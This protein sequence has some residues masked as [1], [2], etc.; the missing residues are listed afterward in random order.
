MVTLVVLGGL[1]WL[2]IK[3]GGIG[4]FAVTRTTPARSTP[5]VS[6]DFRP[7]DQPGAG[8]VAPTL[9][10]PGPF[11]APTQA[12]G[13]HRLPTAAGSTIR[14]AS[15]NIQVFGST[16]AGKPP[17]IRT[18]AEIVRQFDVVAIQEVRSKNDY[19]IPNFVKQINQS[20]DRGQPGRHYEHVIGPRLGYTSSKEQY[21]F[22]FD[23]DR[24]EIDPQ[25]VYTVGDPDGL[26]HREP[27]VATFRARGVESQLAFTFTL[28]NV[29]TDPDQ[30]PEEL[31]ALADVY[32]A[33]RR[34]SQGEDDIILLG[35]FNTDDRH[36][37]RLGKIPGIYPLVVGTWTNTRQNKQ[38][39]NLI[40][41]R[42][43]T[44]EYMGRWGVFD[45]VR[46]WNL[47]EQQALQISDHFPI[48]AEFSVYERDY[49]GR[50]ASRQKPR[51]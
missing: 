4:Q 51:W 36:L 29:H 25:S 20:G 48:W 37:Y 24:V 8:Q 10:E 44:T 21:V 22:I 11:Q 3:G 45:V 39:D 1:G 5:T 46:R 23:T 12:V 9:P 31:D 6:D 33:V 17:V 40:I 38:Y 14:I 43:S 26:M 2:F 35:D 47:T 32:R 34:S 16:K 27:L 13:T 30:V 42:P 49:A 50:I 18:L 19:L 15:F 41:H 28:V 7:W